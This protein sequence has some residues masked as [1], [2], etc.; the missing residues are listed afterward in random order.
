MLRVYVSWFA[1]RYIVAR[2]GRAYVWSV[3]AGGRMVRLRA[4]FDRP[5]GLSFV[6]LRVGAVDVSVEEEL[7][8]WP[9]EVTVARSLV[10]PF[11]LAA[12][13]AYG[14]AAWAGGG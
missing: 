5:P 14:D 11:R 4:A 6:A 12:R 13:S 9:D 2:G 3:A 7:S 1:S 10:P 8:Q